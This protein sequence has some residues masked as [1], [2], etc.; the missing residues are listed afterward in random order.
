MNS[1]YVI[2]C[3]ILS[4][5]CQGG[6]EICKKTSNYI[7]RLL[8]YWVKMS[9]RVNGYISVQRKCLLAEKFCFL[10]RDDQIFE[11]ALSFFPL[12]EDFL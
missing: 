12:Q 11:F 4:D 2:V 5:R 7:Q 10:V 3:L 9:L 8:T 6:E 1:E